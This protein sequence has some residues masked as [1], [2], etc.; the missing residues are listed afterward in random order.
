MLATRHEGTEEGAG[1]VVLDV[2]L[3]ADILEVRL[4][5]RLVGGAPGFARRCRV[6][7]LQPLAIFRTN[8]IRASYPAML[9]KQGIGG[10]RVELRTGSIRLKAGIKRPSV[11]GTQGCSRS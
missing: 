8:T 3:D 9:I 10:R 2:Y 7:K 5:N 6:G 11:I 1:G 4:N